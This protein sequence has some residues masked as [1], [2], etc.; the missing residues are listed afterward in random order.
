MQFIWIGVGGFLGANARYLV[1]VWAANRW[2]TGFPYG[3]AIVNILGSFIIALFLT[4]SLEKLAI[5]TEWR[6][7][8]A[9]GFL[10]SFTTF[11]T[12]AY[13]IVILVSQGRWSI[14]LL[15]M[16]GELFLGIVAV[17]LGIAV[18]RLIA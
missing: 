11:S 4:L 6:L 7:L 5:S 3:T 14:A 13:E 15:N 8:F 12:F 10:G 16:L 18:A 9:V 2:G 17:A 1:S